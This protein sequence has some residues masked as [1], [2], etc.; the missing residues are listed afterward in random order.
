M[1]LDQYDLDAPDLDSLDLPEG[2][3]V[4]AAGSP[5][6]PPTD[7]PERRRPTSDNDSWLARSPF[8]A[9]PLVVSVIFGIERVAM[10]AVV[11]GWRDL[12]IMVFGS[13]FILTFAVVLAAGGMMIRHHRR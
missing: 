11:P 7:E 12:P 13:L 6:A 5:P 9:I 8:W 1:D 10:L 4:D 3:S 2:L